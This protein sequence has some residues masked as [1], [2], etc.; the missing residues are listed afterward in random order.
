MNTAITVTLAAAGITLAAAGCGGSSG[1]VAASRY[2]SARQVIAALDHGGLPCTGPS[3]ATPVVPG[4]S[5]EASCNLSASENPLIDV[6]PGTV[7]TAAVLRN[8]VST[9]TQKIWSDVGPNWWV[10]TSSA[11]VKRVQKILGG[12]VVGGPWHPP[13]APQPVQPSAPQPAQA[14]TSPAASPSCAQQVANWKGTPGAQA[15]NQALTVLQSIS[16]DG[17]VGNYTAVAADLDQLGAVASTMQGNP[18]PSCADGHNYWGQITQAMQNAASTSSG[19]GNDDP[20]AIQQ[21]TADTSQ[22]AAD[23]GSL[24]SELKQEGLWSS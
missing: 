13:S 1:T 4:A 8:S 22:F 17:Q 12:R 20:S 19:V 10:Q 11:Y 3:Y 14:A 5:S 18:V 6:F 2:S 7:T 15:L 16:S 24:I 23:A 21:A 9:G